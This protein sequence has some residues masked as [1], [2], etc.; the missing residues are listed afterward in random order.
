MSLEDGLFEQRAARV[1]EIEA[2]GY[3]PFG[4]RF[5][6]THTIPDILARYGASAAEELVPEI[7]VRI[8]G[9]I[10]TMRR[11]G[12]AGFMHIAQNGER[13]QIYVRKTPSPSATTRST[14]C[15]TSATSSAPKA[16]CSAPAPANSACMSRSSNSSRRPCSPCPKSGTASKTSRSATASAISI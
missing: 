9:R 6:F 13:L 12:K 1:R 7:R 4:K 2:L 5:D 16:I 11:M 8:A 15:S 10:Q 14:N 3:R